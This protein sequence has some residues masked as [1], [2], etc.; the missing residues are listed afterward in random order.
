MDAQWFSVMVPGR[1]PYMKAQLGCSSVSHGYEAWPWP[2]ILSVMSCA[3]ASCKLAAS[4][5]APL[6]PDD[7]A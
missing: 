2:S 1:R 7:V 6:F 4:E 3:M 5:P